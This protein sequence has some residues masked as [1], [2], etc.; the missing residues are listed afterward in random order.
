MNILSKVSCLFALSTFSVVSLANTS[1]DYVKIL[2][3]TN[4]VGTTNNPS[5]ALYIKTGQV[6][7]TNPAECS[8]P[9]DYYLGDT[10]EIS[11]S[12]LLAALTTKTEVNLVINGCSPDGRTPNV[13]AISVVNQ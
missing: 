12:M 5:E 3:L 11:K 1:T 2:A 13:V 6:T 7:V 9:K 10:S 8:A 4:W